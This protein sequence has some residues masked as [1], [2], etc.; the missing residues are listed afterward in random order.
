MNKYLLNFFQKPIDKPILMWYNI[1]TAREKEISKRKEMKNENL[2]G[3]CL[4]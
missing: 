2:Y 4:S 3:R 1:I